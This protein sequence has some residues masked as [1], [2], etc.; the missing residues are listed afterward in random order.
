LLNIYFLL[1]LAGAVLLIWTVGVYNFHR[2]SQAQKAQAPRKDVQPA[3]RLAEQWMAQ[4]QAKMEQFVQSA[5][6]PLGAAQTELLELRL[7]AGRLPQGIKDLRLVRE[8]LETSLKPAAFK[9]GLG[10]MVGVYLDPEDFRAQG[11]SLVLLKTPLGDMPCFE[12]ESGKALTDEGMKAALVGI[13]KVLN[14]DSATGGFLYFSN[15][16]HY[17]ECLQNST[18][19]E[20]LKAR[21][22]MALDFKALTALLISLRLSKDTDRVIR[23]FQEGVDSTRSIIGQSDKMNAALSQ[24]S[25]HSLRVRTLIEGS[26]LESLGDGHEA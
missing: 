7:E 3:F 23:T 4:S 1:T 26:P 22:L 2:I 9:K 6:Q 15:D 16:A 11:A 13:N 21:R 19:M 20:G 8:S 5:E 12:E 14:Q 17:S 10:D 25:G 24:L 18:W